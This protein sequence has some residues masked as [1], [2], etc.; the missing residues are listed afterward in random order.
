M[1]T[2]TTPSKLSQISFKKRINVL[3]VDIILWYEQNNNHPIQY[4]P[5]NPSFSKLTHNGANS[6]SSYHLQ[7]TQ[8]LRPSNIHHPSLPANILY[9]DN[10]SGIAASGTT[11]HCG[12]LYEHPLYH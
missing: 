3:T 11:H 2:T 1:S 10:I 8:A 9:Y 12:T 4:I 7:Q 6:Y 5:R